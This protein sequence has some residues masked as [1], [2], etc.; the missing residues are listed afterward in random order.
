M[1]IILFLRDCMEDMLYE[2]ETACF[3]LTIMGCR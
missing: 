3:I 1:I 2:I